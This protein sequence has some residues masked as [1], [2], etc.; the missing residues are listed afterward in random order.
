[1]NNNT[2]QPIWTSSDGGASWTG[3]FVGTPAMRDWRGIASNSDGKNLI[4]AVE[5]G[6]IWRSTNH[7][8]IWSELTGANHPPVAAWR[9]VTSSGDG[10]ILVAVPYN[11]NIWKSTDSGAT[12]TEDTTVGSTQDWGS[13]TSNAA[14]DRL[15]AVAVNGD[16]WTWPL[17]TPAVLMPDPACDV[18]V[19]GP[20]PPRLW[21]RAP[22][23]C[24][25]TGGVLVPAVP[26]VPEVPAVPAVYDCCGETGGT[27]GKIGATRTIG[28]V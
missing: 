13:V 15:A 28:A 7:G 12:W 9:D 5:G 3:V 21:S 17:K 25:N 18:Q 20:Q 19:G 11:G 10:N 27:S 6:R 22:E 23:D 16:I 14:G 24:I 2:I 4:A 1:M 26:G 8:S